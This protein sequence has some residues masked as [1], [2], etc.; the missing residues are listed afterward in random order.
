MRCHTWSQ[1]LSQLRRSEA[2]R[3]LRTVA[4]L[5]PKQ[6]F[7]RVAFPLRRKLWPPLARSLPL[8]VRIPRL[9]LR[10]SI[11]SAFPL[12]EKEREALLKGRLRMVGFEGQ[13]PE[14]PP[15][16][17]EVRD[18]L[19]RYEFH[20]HGWLRDAWMH[21]EVL[22]PRL[23]AWLLRYLAFSFPISSEAID[24]FP[25]ATRMREHMGLA[26][27]GFVPSESIAPSMAQGALLLLGLSEIHL[28]G[29][30]LLRDRIGLACASLWVGDS[31][32]AKLRK[33]ALEA[34]KQ[35]ALTQFHEDG[36]HIELT[37]SYHSHAL[38]DLLFAIEVFEGAGNEM[39]R[40]WVAR[41][42]E[43]LREIGGRALGALEV[44]THQDGFVCAFGDSAPRS[45]P[46]I[47]EFH[48][49][50]QELMVSPYHHPW[51]EMK[52]SIR[53][54]SLTHSGF[55]RVRG[56]RY[57]FF[58]RHGDFALSYQPGHAHCDLFAFELDI[59]GKRLIVDPGVH[60]Y[61]E[62][63]F[64]LMSRSTWSHSTIALEGS[65][66]AE[67]AEIWHRF[68]CGWKPSLLKSEW[69]DNCFEGQALAF[70]PVEPKRVGRKIWF[71]EE[72]IRIVDEIDGGGEISSGIP[73]APGL[74]VEEV[75]P[76]SLRIRSASGCGFDIVLGSKAALLIEGALV[77]HRFGERIPSERIRLRGM[78]RIEYSIKVLKP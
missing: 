24:P 20:G 75:G 17:P 67:Q 29:N 7:G 77:S 40:A 76:R 53:R 35:E 23:E 74:G 26:L 22:R 5:R 13:W 31:M 18:P 30:H 21:L 63:D 68:R 69:R 50:A 8:Q 41:T 59:D 32:G 27:L 52:P 15:F 49:W 36:M 34:L 37:P 42:I 1:E 4:D 2:A 33:I 64:R 78:G 16:D 39:D 54:Q 65:P 66:G 70:G 56:P 55:S 71:E 73:L 47:G 25:L 38:L 9:P 10:H 43:E 62:P 12:D 60:S 51:V 14:F 44:I 6:I 46:K 61:H 19:Y 11:P 72:E 48:A 28:L 57:E 58:L 45:T 3:W